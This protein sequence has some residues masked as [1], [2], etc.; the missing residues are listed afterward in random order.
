MGN[1]ILGVYDESNLAKSP[2][3][4]ILSIR[5]IQIITVLHISSVSMCLKCC[6]TKFPLRV[7]LICASREHQ[8][9]MHLQSTYDP[10][11]LPKFNSTTLQT[12]WCTWGVMYKYTFFPSPCCSD[13]H[14]TVLQRVLYLQR[15]L[16]MCKMITKSLRRIASRYG[17][18]NSLPNQQWK[19]NDISSSSH[20]SCLQF[21]S[22]SK[23]GGKSLVIFTTWSVTQRSHIITP[24]VYSQVTQH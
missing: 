23:T 13:P 6:I 17:F 4:I 19:E 11:L 3:V 9:Y 1:L 8:I 12:W 10:S 14:R 16:R 15:T 22:L 2:N 7:G 18:R 21:L 24:V 5:R 20:S